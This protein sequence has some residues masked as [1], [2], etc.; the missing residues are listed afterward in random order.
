MAQTEGARLDEELCP[1][2]PDS[3]TST[4][5]STLPGGLSVAITALRE[6]S[7]SSAGV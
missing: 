1:T 4:E 3:I 7:P 6:L 5:V 2:Y